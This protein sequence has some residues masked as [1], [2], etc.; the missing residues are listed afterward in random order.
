[1]TVRRFSILATMS[2]L[3]GALVVPSA[4]GQKF[5]Q[6]GPAVWPNSSGVA[7]CPASVIADPRGALSLLAGQ[8]WV[9]H[10]EGVEGYLAAA[11]NM[12]FGT[13][14]NAN[15][16]TGAT[17]FMNVIETRDI[18]GIIYRF[19]NYNGRYLIFP[20]CSGGT[21]MF[22]S[23][24]LASQEFDFYFAKTNDAS[25]TGGVNE[26]GKM[27]LVDIDSAV[28]GV[29]GITAVEQGVAEFQHCD[30]ATLGFGTLAVTVTPL[31]GC[32]VQ[33]P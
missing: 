33:E 11:G 29:S 8:T 16:Q 28:P 12:Y 4:F 1:M 2:V 5:P 10:W 26:F 19:L 23:G 7:G 18:A 25:V 6:A 31:A 9:Y 24:A 15:S 3:A 32:P 20:D 22:N 30:K 14:P 21:L 17:G 13:V 27:F